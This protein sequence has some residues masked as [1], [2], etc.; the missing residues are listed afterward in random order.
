M[1]KEIQSVKMWHEGDKWFL[2]VSVGK[3]GTPAER[4]KYGPFDNSKETIEKL[5]QISKE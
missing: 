4:E 3:V 2:I 1:S 5:V